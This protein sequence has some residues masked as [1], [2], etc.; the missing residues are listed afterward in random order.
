MATAGDLR[1]RPGAPVPPP[2]H[3]LQTATD[4]ALA[5]LREQ[6][7]EQMEWLGAARA[8]GGWHLPVLE[9]VLTV[10][11]GNGECTTRDGRGVRPPWRILVLHYLGIAGRPVPGDVTGTFADLPG[12]RAYA[13]VYRARVNERLCATAGREAETLRRAALALGARPAEGG[14]LAFDVDVFP[15]LGVRLVWYAGDEEFGPEATLLL[16]A[17]I[18]QMLCMEDIVVVSERLVARLGGQPF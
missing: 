16:P 15:R 11:L 7:A 17:S 4:H 14:D 18:G 9:D 10:D 12:G 1:R 3:N 13:G 8:A 2:Q 6:S 5:R